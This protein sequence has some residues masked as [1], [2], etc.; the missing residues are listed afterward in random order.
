MCVIQVTAY[1][2]VHD[3][4]LWMQNQIH[5]NIITKFRMQNII[6]MVFEILAICRRIYVFYISRIYPIAS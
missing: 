1:K 3:I 4:S 6:Y 5:Y 2:P